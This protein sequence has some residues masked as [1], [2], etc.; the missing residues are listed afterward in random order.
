MCTYKKLNSFRQC[1]IKKLFF[2]ENIQYTVYTPGQAD[3][4]TE[5]KPPSVSTV[6]GKKE[7]PCSWQAAAAPCTFLSKADLRAL[8]AIAA[9]PVTLVL[10]KGLVNVT[11]R[12]PS[13]PSLHLGIRVSAGFAAVPGSKNRPWTKCCT[14]CCL[15]KEVPQL[16]VSDYAV[17]EA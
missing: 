13:F 2:G 16:V 4:A 6:I 15:K 10:H 7:S 5:C 3:T 9:A 11:S 12:A 1:F 8:P 14:D 17:A